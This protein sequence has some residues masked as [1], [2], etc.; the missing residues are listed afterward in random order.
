LN[1]LKLN[2]LKMQ[3]ANITDKNIE[4]LAKL[5][6]NIISEKKDG[7][8][9]KKVVD[10]D[11]LRQ[12]LSENIVEGD[13]ERYR[14]DWPGKK[15]SLLK[16]NTPIKKTLRPS[17]EE[18]K[19]FENT[20]NLYIEGDNFEVLK[21]L[22]E[23]YL[24]KIKMIYIDPPYNTGKDF[25]YKDNFKES[26][27]NFEEKIGLKDEEKNKLFK[28]TDSNGR[29]H[30]DWLSMMYERLLVSRD[31][32]KDDGVIFIS[33]DD[34]EVHNL[35]KI[36]DE[37]FGE[38]NFIGEVI[39]KTKLTSN[40]GTFFAASH[41]YILVYSK[42]RIKSLGFNDSEAQ[43]EDKYLKL[44][45]YEDD[46]SKYN[47]VGLYQPSLDSRP[48]QRYYIKCPDGSFVIPPG[49]VFPEKVGDGLSVKPL[50]NKDKVWRWSFDSYL[51]YD[52]TNLVFKETTTS[53]LLNEY[54]EKSKWNIY[55][56]IYLKDRLKDGILPTTTIDKYP[57]SEASKEL[58]KLNIPF[59]F[60]KPKNLIK[61]L[62]KI[63][64]L[65]KDDL[66]LDFFSGSATTAHAVMDLNAQ[67]GGNR[68][69]IMVQLPEATEE[70]SEAYKAGYKT[71]PEIGKERIRRAGE[72]IL[73]DNKDKENI[74]NLDIGF[75]VLKTDSSNF[76][77]V[78]YH[79]NDLGQQDLFDLES[80]IKEDRDELD[81]LFQIMI[82]L[83]IELDLKIAKEI[84]DNKT[85]FILE[86]SELVACFSE[87][88]SLEVIEK[89]KA[90]NPYKVVLKDGCF[91]NDTD[92]INAIQDLSQ[93]SSVS[94][95]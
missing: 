74:K 87:N 89:I 77:D 64:G 18:S 2:K 58:I 30:S 1:E 28:N 84:V 43:E 45:K 55:T 23:S 61:Y 10:F 17:I 95:I 70:K 33:I 21:L 40:K 27:E 11:L 13:D 41:E 44:F 35:R 51:R 36:C 53:P 78:Y 19:D 22:Q 73:E 82:D 39:R 9:V 56:K 67:D 14:L 79:P 5:F 57:N 86:N 59:D 94:V 90:H 7:N 76:K 92:K 83:G 54:G 88:I 24:N 63:M 71:I 26:K 65:K 81:L 60:S 93:N 47:I 85:I 12:I 29:F 32:L 48:N 72:K 8:T 91:A 62:M 15:A 38:G 80:N 6:P 75:R 31:L 4:K 3:S 66:I 42:N 46:Y 52:K 69:Y 16:A 20:Q 37:V 50:G 25:V 34:N 68:K 49:N